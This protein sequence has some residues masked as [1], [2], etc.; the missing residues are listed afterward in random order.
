MDKR[1]ESIKATA[2]YEAALVTV[3]KC[4]GGKAGFGT[5]AV[6]GQAYQRLVNLGLKPALRAKYRRS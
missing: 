2:E 4:L 5:E 3:K 1:E 6:Y